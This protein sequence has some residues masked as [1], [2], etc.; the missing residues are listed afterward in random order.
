MQLI[1]EIGR[2]YSGLPSRLVSLGIGTTIACFQ[3][4]R[5]LPNSHIL[6]NVASNAHLPSNGIFFSIGYPITSIPVPLLV[7]FAEAQFNSTSV[8]HHHI[9]VDVSG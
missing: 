4:S 5:I 2:Y 8:N 9:S 6:L 1:K 3:I 7:H